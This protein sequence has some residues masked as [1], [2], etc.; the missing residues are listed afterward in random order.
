MLRPG[1]YQVTAEARVEGAMKS[2]GGANIAIN[3]YDGIALISNHLQAT[4]G[5][6]DAFVFSHRRSMGRHDRIAL[7]ARRIRLSGQKDARRFAY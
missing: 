1:I 5:L 4:T 6:A 2:E 7:P 3:T